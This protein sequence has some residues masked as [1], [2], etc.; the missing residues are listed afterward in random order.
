MSEMRCQDCGAITTASGYCSMCGR[1]NEPSPTTEE[2]IVAARLQERAEQ[3][4]DGNSE[5]T[6]Y[7][8]S[9]RATGGGWVEIDAEYLDHLFGRIEYESGAGGGG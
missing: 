9:I 2:R 1:Y 3:C 7:L 8:R 5:G 6:T 4:R